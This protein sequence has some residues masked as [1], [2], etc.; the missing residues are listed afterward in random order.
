MRRC[1]N[2]PFHLRFCPYNDWLGSDGRLNDGQ[3]L[4]VS[5]KD[6]LKAFCHLVMVYYRSQGAQSID[7]ICRFLVRD[8]EYDF[9]L[10]DFANFVSKSSSIGRYSPLDDFGSYYLVLRGIMFFLSN[11]LLTKMSFDY[12]CLS[13]VILDLR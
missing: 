13:L 11:R 5:F 12:V 3:Y 10:D 6:C 7:S 4:F 2:N 8:N 1:L 9:L